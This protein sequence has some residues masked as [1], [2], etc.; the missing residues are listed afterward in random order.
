MEGYQV[1]NW[2]KVAVK[3]QE[4]LE[5]C[6]NKYFFDG[7]DLC[8]WCRS[9]VSWDDNP[10]MCDNCGVFCDKCVTR[11]RKDEK[12]V[13]CCDTK[14]DKRKLS[15][16]E[17]EERRIEKEKLQPKESFGEMLKALQPENKKAKKMAW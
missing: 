2:K 15:D 13:E 11:F 6:A 9:Y 10:Q 1:Q 16:L 5:E 14:S 17:I 8:C 4:L 7:G 3:L 12:C